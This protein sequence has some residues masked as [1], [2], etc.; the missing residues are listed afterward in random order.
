MRP[1][2]NQ[3][4]EN[5][6]TKGNEF[7]IERT[8]DNYAGY[9]HSVSGKNFI[10]ATY[11]S[12]AIALTPY[13]TNKQNAAFNLSNVDSTYLKL[14]PGVINIIKKD[15]FPIVKV[16]FARNR[17]DIVE[18]YR[19]FIQKINTINAPIDEVDRNTFYK[20]QNH[21]FY[22]AATIFWK[23]SLTSDSVLNEAEKLIPGIRLLLELS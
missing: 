13:S 12:K 10:G 6:H 8:Y 4:I 20:A 19:Y 2:K 15:E 7:L 18:K 16:K 23:E 1:P 14:K 3:I 21:P 11:N 5:L 22:R 17:E 9:Y